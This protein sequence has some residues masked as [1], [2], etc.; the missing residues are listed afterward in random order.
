VNKHDLLMII[1]TTG[2][3]GPAKGVEYTHNMLDAL[4]EQM[5]DAYPVEEGEA[6]LVTLSLFAIVDILSGNTAVLAPMDPTRP[7][8]VDPEKMISTIERYSV[9]HMFGSPALLH[10]LTPAALESPDRLSTL[11]TVVCGGAA[12]PV[13]LLQEFRRALPDDV[14][15]HTTYGATE[16]LPIATVNLEMLLDGCTDRTHQGKGVCVGKPLK[17]IEARIIRISEASLLKWQKDLLADEGE[18]GE[19]ILRGSV[20]S[21][22][23]HNNPSADQQHKIEDDGTFWHRTGDVGWKDEGGRLWLCGRGNEIVWTKNGPLYTMQCEGIFNAHPSV[24]RSALIGVGPKGQQQPIL[25]VELHGGVQESA[26]LLL[27]LEAL[28]KQYDC[29]QQ[30]RNFLVHPSFPV[31]IRHNSK[32]GRSELAVWAGAKLDLINVPRMPL[33]VM[34]VPLIGWL[35]LAVGAIWPFTHSWLLG[36]WWLVIF[37][38]FVVHP[39][40]II[41]GLPVA[42]RVGHGTAYIMTMT[43]IFGATYW[44]ALEKASAE[45]I[46]Q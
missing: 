22:A 6:G 34:A 9:R 17:H 35:Y 14:Q 21:Q 7:A 18:V 31:D 43:T 37:L 4:V 19:V 23:Y 42:R 30:I 46:K 25:C 33:A 5:L 39:L 29:T 10:R 12:A 28:S 11:K 15:L 38:H 2:S 26:D 27:A 44:H 45:D 40:Q 3:T 8:H 13:Q 36:L 16:A 32:I 41:K 24:Y 1:F 20:V